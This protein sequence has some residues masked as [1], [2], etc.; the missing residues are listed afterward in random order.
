MG[1]R[2]MPVFRVAVAAAALLAASTLAGSPAAAQDGDLCFALTPEEVSAVVPGTF[3]AQ[4]S[5]PG[6]CQWRGTSSGG[7]SVGV[8]V[9]SYPG[10]AS[11]FIDPAAVET[12]VAGYPAFT[13]TD[14]TT[15]PPGGVVAVEV[16][17]NVVLLIVS[18]SDPAV[19]RIAAASQ[20]ASIAVPRV[21]ENT[22]SEPEPVGAPVD[23]THGD[24]CSL[25]S[26][27]ELSD[28][29][30]TTL[31][32][33]PGF[34]SCRWDSAD[35]AKSVSV[36]FAEGGLTTLKTVYPDGED[37]TVAGQPAYE[38]DMGLPGLGLAGWQIAV[39]LGPDTMSLL[40]TSTDETLDVATIT[41]DLTETAFGNGLQVLPEPEGVVLACG[42]ATPEEIGAAAGVGGTLTVQDYEIAC[43]YEGGKGNKHVTIY[44][45]M[46]DAATFDMAI[47]A[48]GG[49]EIEGP[50]ERSWWM[51]DYDTLA[52]RQ[53]DLALQVTVTPDKETSEAK[54][55]Q[56]AIAI[57]EVLLAP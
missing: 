31:T 13:M 36:S 44:V 15:D 55:Q 17:G 54:L 56:T 28:V 22:S 2:S 48:L 18:T 20:L 12:S 41:R 45:A 52:T 34:E 49:T 19:D 25:F 4:G 50:G 53:G 30:G 33:I 8:M 1:P 43:T 29:M 3:E 42:L 14:A 37:I 27:D 32:A 40:V 11:G 47:E 23:S 24:P 57:M 7:E 21:A 9:Y 39:D 10:S 35:G 26:A 16:G 6:T 5:F 38:N 46:Q 51:A